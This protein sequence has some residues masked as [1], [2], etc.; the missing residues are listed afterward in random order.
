MVHS[1]WER[2]FN[3]CASSNTLPQHG[4]PFSN[5]AKGR[6]REIFEEEIQSAR[7]KGQAGWE[8]LFLERSGQFLQN[9]DLYF[10][11]EHQHRSK[12]PKDLNADR[13]IV[14]P[15][16]R[17]AFLLRPE[18][19]EFSFDS[20]GAAPLRI[21]IPTLEGPVQMRFKGR[22]DRL[23]LSSNRFAAGV[24]D[25]KTTSAKKIKLAAGEVI[26][27]LLYGHAIRNNIEYNTIQLVT[28][29]YL[30]M[31]ADEESELVNL[32]PFPKELFVEE[33]EG[34]L[35]QSDVL[36]AV[37]KYNSDLDQILFEKLSLLATAVK[38]GNFPPNPFSTSAEYCEVCKEVGLS[39]SKKIA[40]EA[41]TILDR[42]NV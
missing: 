18:R 5:E 30:T 27:D 9:I 36:E 33:S 28:F 25:F 6:F 20:E 12:T 42:G 19:S 37:S 34:G 24:L 40:A 13:K 41:Q 4:E 14:P 15:Q 16:L 38:E 31:K 3:E 32:R 1:A 7:N 39:R 8:P 29:H 17:E 26:Q 35:P 23:D 11:L 2:L 10:Q 21:E 22:M